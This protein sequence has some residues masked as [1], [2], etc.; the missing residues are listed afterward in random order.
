MIFKC[1]NITLVFLSEPQA[2]QCELSSIL[3]YINQEYCHS[4][5]SEDI[6]ETDLPL[7]RSKAKGGTMVLWRKYLDPHVKLIDVNSTA[8]LPLLLSMPGRCPS[9]H[10]ALYMPTHGQDTEFVSELASLRN[11]LDHQIA[12]HSNLC[13][14]IRGDSNVNA[15][16][17]NRVSMLKS[18]MQHFNLT[19][20]IIT[21]KTYHHFVG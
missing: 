5:N 11:C 4:L 20:T 2:Y 7:L 6:Y 3:Q 8:F 12:T 21:H 19:E 17:T 14:Y 1:F 15:K 18:F 10:V 16:N 9:L 13:I